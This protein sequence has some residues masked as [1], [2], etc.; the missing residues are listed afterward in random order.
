MICSDIVKLYYEQVRMH[1][2]M[3]N[4]DAPALLAPDRMMLMEFLQPEFKVGEL[5]P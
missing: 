3:G 2:A 5:I 1:G 4:P